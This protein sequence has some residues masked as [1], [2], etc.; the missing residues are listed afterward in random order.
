MNYLPVR[1]VVDAVQ[2]HLDGHRPEPRRGRA[3]QLGQGHRGRRD[4]RR[5]EAA[6]RRRASLLREPLASDGHDGAPE[7]SS[8]PRHNRRD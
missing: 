3:S 2:R 7:R 5:P 6:Q 8:R 4:A 1:G